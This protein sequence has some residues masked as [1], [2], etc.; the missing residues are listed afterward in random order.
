MTKKRFSETVVVVPSETTKAF[1]EKL[2]KMLK[3]DFSTENDEM[4]EPTQEIE[5]PVHEQEFE[6][7]VHEQ[8]FETP[9]REQEIETPV[10][11]Q[12]NHQ[13]KS[14]KIEIE[15][16][17]YLLN[18]L[19]ASIDAN[20]KNVQKPFAVLQKLNERKIKID[21]NIR[22]F[23]STII[24]LTEMYDHI[25]ILDEVNENSNISIIIERKQE[26]DNYAKPVCKISFNST[27]ISIIGETIKQSKIKIENL[28]E[29]KA[30]I[31]V[32]LQ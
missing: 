15:N 27:L 17:T 32:E 1:A 29:I 28:K 7:P 20:K 2:E 18:D 4:Q 12:E 3:T 8:E 5:T 14:M 25:S 9:V 16:L 13:I 31:D 19:R 6:T 30:T 21:H 23:E 11:E 10:H 26:H 22:T 24:T